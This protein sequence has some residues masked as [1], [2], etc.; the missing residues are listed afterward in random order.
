MKRNK[1][2][3]AACAAALILLAQGVQ[4]QDGTSRSGAAVFAPDFFAAFNPRTARDMVGRVPG[5]SISSGDSSVRGFGGS[6]GNVLINGARPSTKSR[7]LQDVL[8]QIPAR[9]VD[10]IE[11]LDG[12][13]AGGA[14]AGG[15]ARIVNVV[16]KEGGGLAGSWSAQGRLNSNGFVQPEGEAS[17]RW[18]RGRTTLSFGVSAGMYEYS[19]LVG[20]EFV[21][22]T[23]G[24]ILEG[25]RNDD[26]RE[27]RQAVL[28]AGLE[29]EIGET[30]VR[31]NARYGAEDWQRDWWH[32]AR[33]NE[34]G[35][36]FRL[37][38]GYERRD[39]HEWEVGFDATHA[40]GP[41]T[42]K[43]VAL[44]QGGV[45]ESEDQAG[46]NPIG[47]PLRFDRF[48][49]DQD[50]REDIARVSAS[51]TLGD[52][53]FEAGVE[54]AKNTLDAGSRLAIGDGVRFTPVAQAISNSRVT[55][56]RTEAFLAD[57][58]T[59]SPKLSL[60]GGV[61]VEWSTIS[62]TG[63]G[64]NERSFVYPKPRIAASWRPAS[65]WT[66]TGRVERTVGQLDFFD[67][68]S[69]AEVGDGNAS[70]GN[71]DLKP[72]RS[73]EAEIAVERRWGER[74]AARIALVREDIE[75]VVGRVILRNGSEAIGNIPTAQRTG[76]DLDL[77]LPLVGVGLKGA[78]FT[79]TWNWRDSEVRDPLTREL[80]PLGDGDGNQFEA[81]IRQDLPESKLS[82][83]AWYFQ[84]DGRRDYRRDQTFRWPQGISWGA[85]VET[86][87]VR[88]LTIELGAEGLPERR[89]QRYRAIWAGDRATGRL[90][91]IQYRERKLDGAIYLEVRGVI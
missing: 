60:E 44:A 22:N 47:A 34:T 58:W 76:L 26:F 20:R 72:E 42:G 87:A 69:S 63:D 12:A 52:H 27:F 37:D 84:G 68:I 40:F 18:V 38:S 4:A 80:R 7:S 57:S 35:P 43:L 71:V 83:G 36:L 19:R 31:L 45:E 78:E 24:L 32:G 85:W 65:G 6:A 79:L 82:W 14:D 91:R 9:A 41:W 39:E 25:G 13:Q 56:T 3:A 33:R 28:T 29:S 59:I 81:G 90:D 62:Q 73:W 50:V 17:I 61:K 8:D 89:F 75:D 46:F 10:R 5:F 49:A 1:L 48:Q 53:A 77:T 70:A 54:W 64:N 88:G 23:A 15:Q 30:T 51:R 67:F 11:L 55:E 2:L 74:G 21:Q 86:T 16:L 66:V